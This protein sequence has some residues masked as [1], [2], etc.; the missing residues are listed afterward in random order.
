MQKTSGR[1]Q[2]GVKTEEQKMRRE[3]WKKVI[4]ALEHPSAPEYLPQTAFFWWTD[5]Q[6]QMYELHEIKINQA[7]WKDEKGGERLHQIH[8][9]DRWECG[10]TSS[11]RKEPR[12]Q[13]K[14]S[15]QGPRLQ[16]PEPR[17]TRELAKQVVKKCQEKVQTL[18]VQK[19]LQDVP[20]VRS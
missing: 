17:L 9:D 4:L 1:S 12:S 7:D 11:N 18:S 3:R 16:E 15:T 2:E 10:N 8:H 6:M 20:S 14:I 19:R 5:Q 13:R